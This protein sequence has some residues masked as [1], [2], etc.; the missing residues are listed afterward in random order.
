MKWVTQTVSWLVFDLSKPNSYT[1][2]PKFD[3]YASFQ[4]Y[5][6]VWKSVKVSSTFTEANLL[7]FS[8][9]SAST[10]ECLFWSVFLKR[11][12]TLAPPLRHTTW[13]KM[14]TSGCFENPLGKTPPASLIWCVRKAT[15]SEPR[16]F[17]GLC[18]PSSTKAAA[19]LN[20]N[21]GAA[22]KCEKDGS[23][24]IAVSNAWKI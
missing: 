24:T 9:R 2:T 20:N 19:L 5:T 14:S 17:G 8:N 4:N 21:N 10:W 7:Y 15:Q 1:A 16:P 22:E 11:L 12:G 3:A 6:K 23:M 18:R 13:R